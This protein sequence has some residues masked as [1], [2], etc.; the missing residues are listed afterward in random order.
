MKQRKVKQ[1]LFNAK[2]I[3]VLNV[4]LSQ[5]YKKETFIL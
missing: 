2:P 3:M 5:K 1:K 4:K